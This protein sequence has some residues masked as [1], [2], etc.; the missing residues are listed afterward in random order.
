MTAIVGIQGKDW[1]VIAAD[2]MTTYDDKPYFSKSFEK[3]ARKGDYVFAFAGDAIA[4]N[5]ANF[6]W[7][8]PKFIKTMP[9]DIFVQTKVLPSLRDVMKDN[10]YEPDTAK[11]PDAGFDALICVN[12]II[13]EVDQDYLW[14]RDDRGLYAVGSGGPIALGA[15][16]TGFSK[17]SV[18]AAEFAAR[19]AIKISADYT[20][21]V[22]G[23]V[24]VITQKGNEMAAAKKIT[25]KAAYAAYE[26]TE[27]KAVKKA[28]MK[29][30]ESKAEKARET[31][32][33][34]AMLKK[35]GK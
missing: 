7:T 18:K 27:S 23:D 6:I 12:G 2:S 3:V 25:K 16:A 8:P 21:S 5:I 15:L 28:E 24:K 29:K 1:A 31:K 11:N 30:G 20:I 14:S 35:K 34:M 22:G 33:G 10:G 13:Y 17:N 4:G 9:T 26:K 19:R 32:A